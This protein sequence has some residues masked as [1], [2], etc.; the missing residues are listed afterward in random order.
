MII[1]DAKEDEVLHCNISVVVVL[2]LFRLNLLSLRSMMGLYVYAIK[3]ENMSTVARNWRILAISSF[4]STPVM[5]AQMQIF[6]CFTKA[7]LLYP[8]FL[9]S[10][11]ALIL[12]MF[13]LYGSRD[14]KP[15][16]TF[17]VHGFLVQ[18]ILIHVCCTVHQCSPF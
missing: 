7:A 5:F 15:C 6:L 4:F 1:A 18:T 12:V 16:L 13:V 10:K 17:L 14:M 9:T 8:A 2:I 11:A 3:S